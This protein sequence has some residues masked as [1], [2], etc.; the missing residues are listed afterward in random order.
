MSRAQAH[1]R[2]GS[3]KPLVIDTAR[4]RKGEWEPVR[5]EGKSQPG[6]YDGFGMIGGLET[7]TTRNCKA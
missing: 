3:A 4:I 2:H 6:I 5:C 7:H 1:E